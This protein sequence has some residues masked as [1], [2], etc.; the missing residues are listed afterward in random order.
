VS[1]RITVGAP[2]RGS[3][4]KR[5][6]IPK[7]PGFKAFHPEHRAALDNFFYYDLYLLMI[8]GGGKTEKKTVINIL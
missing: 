8:G 3:G 2:K 6:D 5:R 7:R 1:I 4:P